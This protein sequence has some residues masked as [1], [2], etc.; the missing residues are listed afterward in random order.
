M[1]V[2]KSDEAKEIPQPHLLLDLTLPGLLQNPIKGHDKPGN[3]RD[4]GNYD[5]I[6]CGNDKISAFGD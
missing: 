4:K 1:N 3:E 6:G 5:G 2:A